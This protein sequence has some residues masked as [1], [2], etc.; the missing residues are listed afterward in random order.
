[1]TAQSLIIAVAVGLVVGCTGR[2][3][4]RRGRSVPLWLPVAA[5]VA[6]AVLAAVITRMANTDQP[7]PTVIEVA[8]QVLFAVIGVL[9]VAMT[10][11]RQPSETRWQRSGSK[12]R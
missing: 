9:L 11:D 6:A 3:L 4:I 2:L 12:T 8:L 5:G 10:A 7:G 1:M